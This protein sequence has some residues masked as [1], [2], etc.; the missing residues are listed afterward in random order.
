MNGKKCLVV[1]IIVLSMG[2][3]FFDIRYIINWGFVRNLFD[4]YLEVGRVGR[5]RC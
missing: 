1:V 4:R 3:N 2:I 5:D